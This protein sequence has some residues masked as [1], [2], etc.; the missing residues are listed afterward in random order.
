MDFLEGEGE[1]YSTIDEGHHKFTIL[2]EELAA[3]SEADKTALAKQLEE[4][5][6]S[7][8]VQ[9]NLFSADCAK[10]LHAPPVPLHGSRHLS[11][12]TMEL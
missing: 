4:A 6:W 2:E 1:L 11:P 3:A 7:R 8:H 12:S 10:R 9:V 5:R